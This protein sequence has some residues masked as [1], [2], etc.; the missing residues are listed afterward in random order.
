MIPL[1]SLFIDKNE[2]NEVKKVFNSGWLAQGPKNKELEEMVSKYLGIKHV[3]C[4]SSCTAALHLSLLGLGIVGGEDSEVLVSDFTFPATGHSVRYCGMKPVFV[5]V[6]PKTYNMD[7]KDLKRKINKKTKAII[8]VHIFGQSADMKKIMKIADEYNIPVIEDAACALGAKYKGRFCG[9][10][11]KIGC[12]SMHATKTISSG[13]EGGLLITDDDE[14]ASRVRSFSMFGKKSTWDREISNEFIIP[15]FENIGFNYKMG[16]VSAAIGMI[17]FKKID[18]II[19]KKNALA[20]YWNKKLKEI[21][22]ISSPYVTRGKGNLH[23]YQ[24]YA[25]L[26]SEDIDRNKLIEALKE[27]GVQTQIGTYSSY[28]QPCYNN[29]DDNCN[30]S[31]DIFNRA[32]RF[33]MFY[34]LKRKSI[35]YIIDVL[36]EIKSQV[37]IEQK[38][39][40]R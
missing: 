24:S 8:V 2:I 35:N 30:I 22:Y 36:K 18:K 29:I 12:F 39:E 40:S 7:Y 16:D 32:I 20:K 14:I 17:Q 5:D 33:P 31:K 34:K 13:G 9:T 38:K 37:F 4:L 27:K 10:I 1:N 19:K 15:T 11:G 26:V 3:I 6:D 28:I 23:S 21:D 25:C